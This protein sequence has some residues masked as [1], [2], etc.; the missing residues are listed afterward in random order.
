LTEIRTS[1]DNKTNRLQEQRGRW[2]SWGGGSEMA[3]F[4][5]TQSRYSTPNW[6]QQLF[7]TDP[8][9]LGDWCKAAFRSSIVVPPLDL[10]KHESLHMYLSISFCSVWLNKSLSFYSAREIDRWA[11]RHD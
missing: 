2:V 3:M 8:V 7:Q 5:V 4:N 9:L 6:Y 11:F 1:A 10:I